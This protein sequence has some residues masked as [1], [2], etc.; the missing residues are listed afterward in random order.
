MELL[1]TAKEMYED[2]TAATMKYLKSLHHYSEYSS[3]ELNKVVTI[4]RNKAQLKKVMEWFD[5][6]RGMPAQERHPDSRRYYHFEEKE[7]QALLE[8]AN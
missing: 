5:T 4:A 7:W 3:V 2:E 1:L 8:E 6:H